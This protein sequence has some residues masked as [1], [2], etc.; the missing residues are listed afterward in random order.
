MVSWCPQ[1]PHPGETQLSLPGTRY[2]GDE[3]IPVYFP[4]KKY[5]DKKYSTKPA[6]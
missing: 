5:D 6:T 2:S 3:T 1:I 4:G